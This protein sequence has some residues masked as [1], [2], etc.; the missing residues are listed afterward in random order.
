MIGL[1]SPS[2][3]QPWPAL[4]VSST[5]HRSQN[6]FNRIRLGEYA[7]PLR[8]VK[9]KDRVRPPAS[10]VIVHAFGRLFLVRLATEQLTRFF[11]C[12]FLHAP[13]SPFRRVVIREAARCSEQSDAVVRKSQGHQDNVIYASCFCVFYRSESHVK[14][15]ILEL[16]Q[17][18]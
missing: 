8:E 12:Q 5:C 2:W 4:L 10:L 14:F 13:I 15:F 11:E 3:N 16:E 9:V 18:S 7:P 1:V 6:A 17:S